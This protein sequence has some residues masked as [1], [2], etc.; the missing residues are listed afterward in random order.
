MS[1]T[2]KLLPLSMVASILLTACGGGGNS[3]N[4]PSAN[5]QD[6]VSVPQKI[7]IDIPAAL[8]NKRTTNVNT[9]KISND[10][11]LENTNVQSFGYQQLTGTISQAEETINSVKENMKYLTLMMPDIVKACTDTAQNT[12]CTIPADEIKLTVQGQTLSMGE[13]LYTQQDKNKKYQQVVVLDLK[14]TLLT[15]GQVGIEKDLETV[16]WS[17]DENHI[18]T[19]SDAKFENQTYS[20]QLR[21]DKAE[22]NSSKMVITDSFSDAETQQG[23]FTLKLDDKNDANHTVNVETTGTFQIGEESDTFN[24]QG[25]VSD[26]GGYL[27]SKGSYFTTSYAEKETFD[28][29]GSLLKSSFCHSDDTCDMNKPETWTNFDDVKG[30]VDTFD[31][32]SLPKDIDVNVQEPLKLTFT[33]GESFPQYTYCEI[34]PSDYNGSLNEDDIYGHSIGSFAKFD[35]ELF[36]VLFDINETNNINSLPV[37]CNSSE[38]SEFSQLADDKRPILGIKK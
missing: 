28:V 23:N 35:D 9:E 33:Q 11:S 17:T 10:D 21:Y 4:N 14:P 15:M 22:D 5:N 34:L 38:N 37:L 32:D 27:V 25:V 13:I 3:D 31:D 7:S 16:K 26:N 19:L 2:K 29:T 24:S 6:A 1:I 36:G 12:T 30:F 8:K 20:M 18:E